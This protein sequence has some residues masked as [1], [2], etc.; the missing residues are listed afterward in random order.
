M[1]RSSA[2]SEPTNHL[3]VLCEE[4]IDHLNIRDGGCYVDGTFGAGG[5]SINILTRAK[6]RLFA[7]DRDPAAIVVANKLSTR[8]G[9]SFVAIQGCF[10]S[11]DSLLSGHGVEQ[12]DAVVLDLGISSNQ[13]DDPVRGFSFRFDGPLDMR[14]GQNGVTAAEVVNSLSESDLADVIYSLG[15][16]KLS[17]Q[18]S[19][20]I[21]TARSKC[22]I[23]STSKLADIVR[24]V[25]PRDHRRGGSDPATKT[26]QALRIYI[27][28][29]LNELDRG[30][31]A[32]E[33]LLVPGGRLVVVAFHSLEDRRVKNFFKQR[34]AVELG[35][36]RH[37][38]PTTHEEKEPSFK[39]ITK[40]P[41]RPGISE[42]TINPRAR[43]ARLRVA[44]R[45]AAP[46]WT[47][48]N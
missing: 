32:A 38:P 11:M 42:T 47:E 24:G 28:D 34:Q 2:A 40:R 27:N 6:C 39:I 31:E 41:L 21:A 4:A 33:R 19:R 7:I 8:Y 9:Q 20:A 45:T 43:S 12:V 37:L 22:P 29:E 35:R 46:P 17:R 5:Y 15:E 44:E 1:N 36:S 26:F 3:P 30:L 18:V 14:M 23:H 13:L 16:E 48:I 25:V 10:G